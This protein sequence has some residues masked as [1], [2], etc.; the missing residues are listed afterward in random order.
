MLAAVCD[1]DAIKLTPRMSGL[2]VRRPRL[3]CIGTLEG[4]SRMNR[5]F[6][7]VSFLLSGS[8]AHGRSSI[9]FFF[10]P[11]PRVSLSTSKEAIR[12]GH[13]RHLWT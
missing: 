13:L 8:S 12:R 10:L 11:L 2:P 9:D 5:P 6:A 1:F 7:Q 3:H 4:I